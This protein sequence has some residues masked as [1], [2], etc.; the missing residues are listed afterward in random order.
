MVFRLKLEPAVGEYDPTASSFPL[1]IVPSIRIAP[2]PDAATMQHAYN[3]PVQ[4]W[5]PGDPAM[6]SRDT[7][8]SFSSGLWFSGFTLKLVGADALSRLPRPS[9]AAET[10]IDSFSDSF[11]TGGRR[12]RLDAVVEVGPM[13]FNPHE[14]APA[15]IV[16]ARAVHPLTGAPLH[17][18]DIGGSDAASS[19]RSAAAV[20]SSPVASAPPSAPPAAASSAA[21][22][23]PA[24]AAVQ[25]S[26][27][28]FNAPEIDHLAIFNLYLAA[29][30]DVLA[31]NASA[32]W[33]HY[34]LLGVPKGPPF[35]HA[36]DT[37]V[38]SKECSDLSRRLGNE[39]TRQ[40]LLR[41][42]QSQFR[43]A[44]ASAGAGPKTGM[45]L[46]RTQERLGTYD[47]GSGTF[48]VEPGF[49]GT[50]V[51]ASETTGLGISRESACRPGYQS[52][53]Q[54]WCSA[55][56]GTA[57]FNGCMR[58]FRLQ[59]LGASALRRMP[60]ERAAAEAF[61]NADAG[62]TRVITLETVVEVGPVPLR[63]DDVAAY[64]AGKERIQARVVAARALHPNS[65]TVLHTF[66][67]GGTP[68]AT[69]PGGAAAQRPAPAVT[70]PDRPTASRPAARQSPASPPATKTSAPAQH[71]F[72]FTA[73]RGL[74]LTFR[75]Q[76]DVLTDQAL[77]DMAQGQ[78][79]AE[80]N[81]WRIVSNRV[82]SGQPLNR[83]NPK[84]A[85]FT[86]EWQT[87]ADTDPALAGGLLL[88]TFLR[89]DADWSF[90]TADPAW[91]G[92]FADATPVEVFLF[93]RDKIEGRD[94]RF[95]AQELGSV[96]GRHL[97]MAAAKAH[98]SLSLRLRMPP[99]VYDF[100]AKALRFLPRG[101][102]VAS[103]HRP[104]QEQDLLEDAERYPEH[105]RL[106]QEANGRATYMLM[107][108]SS[109]LRRAEPPSTKPGIAMQD[110]PTDAWRGRVMIGA[111][112]NPVPLVELLALDRRAQIS[113]VPIDP[114]RAEALA[115]RQSGLPAMDG[116][117][118]TLFFDAERV[119]LGERFVARKP[120]TNAVLLAR[121]KRLDVF[122]PDGKLITSFPADSLPPPEPAQ[123]AP[124]PAPRPA[125]QPSPSQP[126]NAE[127]ERP[128]LQEMNEKMNEM[129]ARI[130][131][132]TVIGQAI[133]RDTQARVQACI[134]LALKVHPDRASPANQRAVQACND[135]ASR[136]GACM[137]QADRAGIDP[138]TPEYQKSV[139]ACIQAVWK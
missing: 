67:M 66:V 98:T 96:Y 104:V 94:H 91:D 10:F 9:G 99:G 138:L 38:R 88:D 76:P 64:I 84:R 112:S 12:V 39:I 15:K 60:M 124:A 46:L 68:A 27:P 29:H 32:A 19:P 106:P 109:E 45:F 89:T 49:D 126:G 139:D 100:Q 69:P 77:I 74:L 24:A 36:N 53:R 78:V 129:T 6:I 95:A 26:A 61:L 108:L 7:L 63:A 37:G 30:A 50:S 118:A 75:D 34:L 105:Y 71:A 113:T 107:G 127:R 130:N 102:S 83:L 59:I 8:M 137:Q 58:P 3:G 65:G 17:T 22:P 125:P 31:S 44:L 87:L 114:A 33:E 54:N 103:G 40:S 52:T 117:T 56:I 73:Y 110:G 48:T 79:H 21:A 51:L 111:G 13:P 92:R 115:R 128:R 28:S 121:V 16:A 4:S 5:C 23:R 131:R 20:V 97:K 101:A 90:V 135:R 41:E 123:T 25:A 18:F 122:D 85:A 14:A 86:Y 11:R 81:A 134:Q 35:K 70:A 136:A 43:T 2:R 72:P 47:L 1:A 132:R 119:V 82:A 80:Q 42:A 55:S 93:A 62:G 133:L 116:F 57:G 120:T